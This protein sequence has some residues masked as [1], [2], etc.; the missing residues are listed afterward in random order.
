MSLGVILALALGAVSLLAAAGAV[1][2]ATTAARA[3]VPAALK[4]AVQTCTERI[5]AVE[6]LVSAQGGK[7][8]QWRTEME[9]VF[10]AVEDALE[11]AETKR[12]RADASERRAAK[13]NGD[14]TQEDPHTMARRLALERGFDV[15]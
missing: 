9:G 7:L 4:A 3:S 5:D 1:H 8:V 11:R 2:I 14:V 12:K 6:T 10:D 15:T 13:R